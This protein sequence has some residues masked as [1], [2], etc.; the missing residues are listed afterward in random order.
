MQKLLM[1][2]GLLPLLGACGDDSGPMVAPAGARDL[3]ASAPDVLVEQPGRLVPDEERQWL[4][5][6]RLH[7][8]EY[9]VDDSGAGPYVW[10]HSPKQGLDLYATGPADRTIEFTAWLPAAPEG[11][12]ATEPVTVW[13]NGLRIGEVE[14]GRTPREVSVEAKAPVW[15]PG[16]NLFELE[17]ENIRRTETGDELS[18]ALAEVR[19]DVKRQVEVDASER[20]L[21]L[22]EG[23]RARWHYEGSESAQLYLTAR[24]ESGGQVV[25]RFRA[26]DTR[27]GTCADED[28][29]EAFLLVDEGLA[30]DTVD[31]PTQPGAVTRIEVA[32]EGEG[33]L[34]FDE[35]ALDGPARPQMPPVLFLSIDTL[36]AGHMSVYG[37]ERE[38]TPNLSAFAEDAVVFERCAT[39]APWTLP[40][41][42][43]QMTG[44]YP[45]AHRLVFDGWADG[46]RP[47]LWDNW[48]LAPNRWTLAEAMR[49][50]GYHTGGFVDNL[51]LT[52]KLNFPQGFDVY[53]TSAG[54]IPLED[55]DGGIR[56]TAPQA[57]EWIESLPEGDPFFAFVHA[58]DVHGPYM[59]EPFERRFVDDDLWR[60]DLIAPAGGTD[61]S[62]GAV[63]AYI[64]EA[65]AGVA[66]SPE[67][68]AVAPIHADYDEEIYNI[69]AD[70]GALFDWLKEQGL[71]ERLLIVVSADHGETIDQKDFYFGH[72]VV[73]EPVRHIPL[74]VKL[75][76]N[77]S[78]GLR[79]PQEVQLVDLYPTL[80]DYSGLDPRRPELHGRSLRPL[81]EGGSLEG[82]PTFT[83]AG[84][85]KQFAIELDG[86]KLIELRPSKEASLD[87][88][89]TSPFLDRTPIYERLPELR[90]KVLTQP[91]I[92][93]IV[94]RFGR[95]RLGR[96]LNDYLPEVVHELYYLPDDPDELN[97]LA[98]ARPEK[99][100]ELLEH[101][102]EID[103]LI[104]EAQANAISSGLPVEFNS[105]ETQ[106]LAAVGYTSDNE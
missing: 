35:L 24:G 15:K 84:V 36:A 105:S 14:L 74:M 53:D 79:V 104:E 70:L 30:H 100:A 58:F 77:Q 87:S 89:L 34:E 1:C 45:H 8:Y 82:A 57:Q 88:R 91:M 39:N 63:P 59:P 33:E 94:E 67:E 99:L 50:R 101:A 13:M 65:E 103:A 98:E 106:Q 25:V 3:L 17:V 95:V 41:Y 12:P 6:A 2:V 56:M 72:G 32:W 97:N 26:F 40:S 73:W 23:T 71:Y 11:A 5:Y 42:M 10:G 22:E 37:Y 38:T 18:L 21:V 47:Q 93:L 28:L 51:W 43:S 27:T 31:V 90:G 29:A 60:E 48:E 4:P 54:L 81:L 69:D 16:R 9:T 7:W 76:A 80:L 62:F 68:I 52:E 85:M 20:E 66:V 61:R 44:L 83:Q 49:S 75:P 19:Y 96:Y 86:W 102:A 64:A 78:A 55:A 46:R 92:D